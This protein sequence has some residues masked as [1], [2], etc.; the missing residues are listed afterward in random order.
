MVYWK[1]NAS[2]VAFLVEVP[3]GREV[4][5]ICQDGSQ[6]SGRASDWQHDASTLPSAGAHR[7]TVLAVTYR[8]KGKNPARSTGGEVCERVHDDHRSRED[9]HFLYLGTSQPHNGTF[10]EQGKR[11]LKRD[12]LIA[13]FGASDVDRHI[14]KVSAVLSAATTAALSIPST[15]VQSKTIDVF[16]LQYRF[17]CSSDTHVAG[18]T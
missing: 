17:C 16:S 18:T 2:L 5:E 13:G 11:P 3:F 1:Y 6:A 10:A 12:A 7:I 4:Q 8:E 14:D 9:A 15:A